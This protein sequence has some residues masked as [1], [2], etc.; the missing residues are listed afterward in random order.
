M[1]V[2]CNVDKGEGTRAD[3]TFKGKTSIAWTDGL[4]TWKPFRIP[5]NAGSEPEYNLD[6][7][8]SFNLEKHV[9]GIGMT[10]WNWSKRVSKYVAFD[11]D[12]ISGHSDRHTRK[13]TEEEL[14]KVRDAVSNIPWVQV[15]K[16]TSGK[17]LHF[18]V[19]VDDVPTANH[20]EH[21]ALARA[22]LGMLSGTVGFDF[23]SKL[24][25]MGGNMWV[26]HRRME[27]TDGLSIIKEATETCNVPINW[28]SHIPVIRGDRKKPKPS[29][30]S[31]EHEDLFENLASTRVTID[32]ED[33]HKRLL[34]HLESMGACAYWD[35][36]RG[37]LVAHTYELGLA[38]VELG[39][40][41]I[42][43]TLATGTERGTDINC[44]G[45]PMRN[46]GW[47]LRRFTPGVEEAPTWSQDPKG[48]TRCY[49]N[50]E[51]DLETAARAAGGID[52]SNS[53]FFKEAIE[54]QEAVKA[55]G[56]QVELPKWAQHRKASLK[57]ST[58]PNKVVIEVEKVKDEAQT[59]EGWIP[60]GKVYRK[61]VT[62]AASGIVQDLDINDSDSMVRN[63]IIESGTDAGWCFLMEDGRWIEEPGG[64]I[65]LA[66]K[67]MG[68]RATDADLVMGNC[69]RKPWTIVNRPFKE[70]YPGNRIWN[71]TGA[72]LQFKP[73]VD[74]DKDDLSYPHWNMIFDHLGKGL[75]TAIKQ[76]DWCIR[77]D[78]LNGA[79]YLRC[80]VAS[81]FQSP[82]QPLP[83]LFFFGDQNVGKS[84]L[85]EALEILIGSTGVVRANSA[86]TS[87]QGFNGELASA[88]VCVVEELDLGS[89][90]KS[91]AYNRIKD[92]VVGRSIQI[93]AKHKTPVGVPNTT[94]W[95][96]IANDIRYC[97]V[98][99]GDT[100][101]TMIQVHALPTDKII[102]KKTLFES[103]V[104]ESPDFLAAM[105]AMELPKTDSRFNVPVIDTN[106]KLAASEANMDIVQDF[107]SHS[108]YPVQGA[109]ITLNRA[110]DLYVEYTRAVYPNESVLTLRQFTAH[111]QVM[112]AKGQKLGQQTYFLANY[113]E[114]ISNDGNRIQVREGKF[115]TAGGRQI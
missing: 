71:K 31:D 4:E 95:I 70:E 84:T 108:I 104:Q 68:H 62:I 51:A 27:G 75:D 3:A 30:L 19:F 33:E 67:S 100:R 25:V 50:R 90:K 74:K 41:G 73:T 21:A 52:D 10:G 22:I 57:R 66:L 110:Y 99:P 92:W 7:K 28:Q 59:L 37:M 60:K 96:Q 17:G 13:C 11:F 44:F 101:I 112:K 42:F 82:D 34:T 98:F 86:L 54:A 80:W 29:T 1:E 107:L 69:I 36:D 40:K 49:F 109:Y 15:R 76:N 65:K 39:L 78:I 103:L 94:H 79:D 111:N 85:Q 115:Y 9:E 88:V 43:R 114:N 55:L 5:H 53:Y 26:W 83:Y 72:K 2:Q 12:A 8:M 113:S 105:L 46:G 23:S 91:Q 58:E 14:A 48:W 61:V 89:N 18:Y 24:D 47:V 63:M 45:Y 106:E 87:D 38:H 16:S 32:L 93:H 77:N 20:H 102:P 35:S 6:A 64:N 56:G 97:P 81:L